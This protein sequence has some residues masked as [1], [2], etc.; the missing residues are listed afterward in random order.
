MRARPTDTSLSQVSARVK[1][2][3][4]SIIKEHLLVPKAMLECSWCVYIYSDHKHFGYM[5]PAFAKST[6]IISNRLGN[7]DVL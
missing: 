5:Q 4:T 3:S 6:L 1:A 2:N 7:F